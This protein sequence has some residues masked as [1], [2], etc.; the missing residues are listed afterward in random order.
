MAPHGKF[1]WNELMTDDVDKAKAFYG[2]VFGWTFAEMPM[3]GD[4][5]YYVAMI[6]EEPVA[7]LM[8]KTDIVPSHVPPHWFSYVSVDDVD[9]RV[10]L[11]EA[12]GGQVVRAPFDIEGVGRIAIVADAT[13]APLGLMTAFED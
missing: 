9:A 12:R 5:L 3:E 8:D 11:L 2:A 4:R 13:G 10:A 7:G 1:Y 6:G